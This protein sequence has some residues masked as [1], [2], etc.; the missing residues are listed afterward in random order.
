M[1][2]LNQRNVLN[3]SVPP[4]TSQSSNQIPTL[5]R[6]P[7]APPINSPRSDSL[8]SP[9]RQPTSPNQLPPSPSRPFTN[10][11]WLYSVASSG[12]TRTPVGPPD[13]NYGL[14]RSL[15]SGAS[16]F[17][18]GVFADRPLKN[19]T[20]AVD[21]NMVTHVQPQV[22]D[23]GPPLQGP[24][25]STPGPSSSYKAG[26]LSNTSSPAPSRP[27]SG[28][29]DNG[30][31]NRPSPTEK[32][33]MDAL[34]MLETRRPFLPMVNVP[35]TPLESTERLASPWRETPAAPAAMQ[36][37]KAVVTPSSPIDPSTA[38]IG[39]QLYDNP[40]PIIATTTSPALSSMSST[41]FTDGGSEGTLQPGDRERL[42][43][44]A[45]SGNDADEEGT[46]TMK[47]GANRVTFSQVAMPVVIT[48]KAKRISMRPAR[49][50]SV[51]RPPQQDAGEGGQPNGEE[52]EEE[53][54]YY[55]SDSSE[56]DER[57]WNMLSAPLAIATPQAIDTSG[58]EEDGNSTLG[59]RRPDLTFGPY[60]SPLNSGGA[61]ENLQ[62]QQT[63][64]QAQPQ[65]RQ[66]QHQQHQ[67][68]QQTRAPPRV[69]STQPDSPLQVFPQVNQQP[70]R[71]PDKRMQFHEFFTNAFNGWLAQRQLTLDPPRVEGKVVELHELFLMVGALGGC[72][73]VCEKKLWSIVAAKIGFPYFNGPPPYS[74]PDVADQVSKFYREV[75]ADF[76]VHWHNSLRPSDPNSTFPLP[77]QLQHLRPAIETLA[78]AQLP[79]QQLQEQQQCMHP[80]GA[81]PSQQP[82]ANA[83]GS[84]LNRIAEKMPQT[85]QAH[86]QRNQ[87]GVVF[88][89]HLSPSSQGELVVAANL[90]NLPSTLQELPTTAPLLP[91]LNAH[92]ERLVRAREKVRA[93]FRLVRNQRDYLS[94]NLPEEQGILLEQSIQQT[95]SMLKQVAQNLIPFV[96]LAPNDEP[97][98]N[99][100]ADTIVTIGDQAQML[101]K[102]PSEKRFIF[103]LRDLTA[104]RS[105][106]AA[107]LMRVKSLQSQAMA[108]QNQQT[109]VPSKRGLSKLP[110]EVEGLS[111]GGERED[112]DESA[113]PSNLSP[114][115]GQLNPP[116]LT[117]GEFNEAVDALENL[118]V[119]GILLDDGSDYAEVQQ[120]P[121]PGQPGGRG[122]LRDFFAK[123][124]NDW[125][126]QRQ[127]TLDTLCVGG[128]EVELDKLFIMVGALGGCRA[129]SEK[130]LWPVVGAKIGCPDFNAPVP[131]SKPEVAY[132]LS[133]IYQS[134]LVDFEVYWDDLLRPGDS[135]STFPLPPQ[136]QYLHPEINR[137]A[138]AR[139][140][141]QQPHQPQQPQQPQSPLGAGPPPDSP[142]GNLLKPSALPQPGGPQVPATIPLL[143]G[144]N[145]P[146]EQ[147]FKAQEKVRAT[148]SLFHNRRDYSSVD[149]A[150]DQKIL[151]EESIAQTQSLLK[152][153]A[154]NLVSFVVLAPNDER[155]LYQVAQTVMI[156]SD[157]AQILQLPPP[158]KRFIMGLGD[159][160]NY[161]HHLTKFL[162]R[163]NGLQG[164][165]LAA[166]N[167]PN[168]GALLPVPPQAAEQEA[169]APII[170]APHSN[171]PSRS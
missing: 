136:L 6:G 53:E 40:S 153:V 152:H 125:L 140:P 71:Q 116:H 54:Y 31:F 151:M 74:K 126:A 1:S 35:T 43:S 3:S 108:L 18:S 119:D 96:V 5:A 106:L 90:A 160:N 115:E 168:S 87:P 157:Q 30:D 24:P 161:R 59:S 55:S 155:E 147:L 165:A 20:N 48:A 148:I 113:S 2:D 78:T 171:A 150:H 118:S 75:L 135:N 114:I 79:S 144:F 38:T 104:Y 29:V 99:Q 69:A 46:G 83:R 19:P 132:Q 82:D 137:L 89:S 12:S 124:F 51:R 32:S 47:P 130:N 85:S 163:V 37:P 159:L 65:L 28:D 50:K 13:Y 8:Y 162:M 134:I 39:V 70:S 61:F 41:K 80:L 21:R 84:T 68:R 95:Q 149:L 67:R 23:Q 170:V 33:A 64:T 25:L 97:E 123:E 26:W 7:S 141:L 128:R 166:Q 81:M 91:D 100:I 52:D 158:E 11:T 15:G 86:V 154:Q 62:Q 57:F 14:T 109:S 145:L 76:E 139:L 10:P 34:S 143:P 117:M 127:L 42:L 131:Y 22:W 110:L 36:I 88:P 129:V 45:G 94:I 16:L 107:F 58:P 167:Q 92:R 138:T 49:A 60:S 72:R 93:M 44:M 111:P 164:Q 103:G 77:P 122:R 9:S 101:Q 121:Q 66:Q 120:S 156:L 146:P 142:G 73:A 133:K 4:Q 63:S 56:E 102:N 17:N 105:N 98:L 169:P 112:D 27:N